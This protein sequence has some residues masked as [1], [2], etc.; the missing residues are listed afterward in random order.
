MDIPHHT[1]PSVYNPYVLSYFVSRALRMPLF[2]IVDAL[3]QD[4][5]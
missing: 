4:S 3:E 1:F 2:R 5:V